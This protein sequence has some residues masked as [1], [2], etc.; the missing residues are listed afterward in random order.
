VLFE[1]KNYDK[2][3]IGKEE[4]NQTRN[5]LAKPNG[6]AGHHLLQS[7]SERCGA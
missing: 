5:Y 1:F 7:R 4:T 6:E 3:E 2:E